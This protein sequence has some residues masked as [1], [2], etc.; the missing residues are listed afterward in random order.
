MAY[1]VREEGTDEALGNNLSHFRLASNEA[2][3]SAHRE[4]VEQLQDKMEQERLL[5]EDREV[6]EADNHRLRADL[7]AAIADR[8]REAYEASS[9]LE[10]LDAFEEEVQMLRD[11]VA[12]ETA[13]RRSLEQRHS[14]SLVEAISQAS[15][16]EGALLDATEKTKVAELLKVELQRAKKDLDA[17][18]ARHQE[19]DNRVT[20]LLADQAETLRVM[21]DA[22]SRGADLEG[23]IRIAREEGEQATLALKEAALEKE[24]L[25]RTQANEADRL[26]RDQIAEANGDRAVLEH[27]FSEVRAEL[28]RRSQE[29][30]ELELE[31]KMA[32]A[33]QLH[34]QDDLDLGRREKDRVVAEREQELR[35]MRAD[36][37][38]GKMAVI[39][40]ERRL[41]AQ[42]QTTR[43]II[44]VAHKMRD[45]NARAMANAQRY[46]TAGSKAPAGASAETGPGDGTSSMAMSTHFDS[47][48]HQVPSSSVSFP[49]SSSFPPSRSSANTLGSSISASPQ[50]IVDPSQPELA[51]GALTAFDLDAFA[52]TVN[53]TGSTIRKW[54]K[55]CKEYR[56]RARGKITYRNFAKGD[57]ALFLPTRNSVAKPWAAFNGEFRT[58]CQ[59]LRLV[60]P[61]SPELADYIRVAPFSIFSTLLPAC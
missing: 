41:G 46:I 1:A 38:D 22:R 61:A 4:V 32:R 58:S 3:E 24:A 48:Q 36:L 18:A 49:P 9:R 31:L 59:V 37:E 52:E 45:T 15:M 56:E 20:A 7:T 54:Q 25:L 23:Q 21:E 30:E 43:E 42:E 17:A 12:S 50:P 26:L 55:Q 13:A 33:N 16:L 14:D 51:L 34:V 27:Q 28:D 40:L 47:R 29:V 60:R 39:D 5:R 2:S 44:K 19:S 11:Q 6:L 10:R 53:K 57:L 8:D 35:S